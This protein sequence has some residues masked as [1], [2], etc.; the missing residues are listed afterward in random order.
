[1]S[2]LDGWLEGFMHGSAGLGM[3]LL[4]SLLLGLRHASDPDHLAAV[5]TLVASDEERDKLRKAG[6]LGLGWGLGHGTTLVLVGLPLVL[7]G[8][9]LPEP[10]SQAAEVVIGV[11]ILLLAVRLLARWRP[12]LLR[13]HTHDHPAGGAA[14]HR[15]VHSHAGKVGGSHEHQHAS[16]LR[17]PLS[18]Y[19]VGLVHGIGGAHAA[20]ALDDIRQDRGHGSA[21]ALRGGDG[22]LHGGALDRLR[23]RHSGRA[24]RTKLRAGGSGIGG[25]G[26]GIRP[27][28][29]PRCLGPRELPLLVYEGCG[30]ES[31]ERCSSVGTGPAPRAA[32]A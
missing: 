14:P 16:A 22:R 32:R 19:G 30:A 9:Y 28:V 17:T 13:A 18:A 26:R 12:G 15:H 20:S 27:L 3:V 8:R 11:I 31:L 25:P 7:V 21:P 10:V 4:V 24:D 5:T 2:V 29:R 23:A 6:L 1:M